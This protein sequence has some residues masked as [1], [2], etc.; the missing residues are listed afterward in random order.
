MQFINISLLFEDCE[1]ERKEAAEIK[2]YWGGEDQNLYI[3]FWKK[4]GKNEKG[5]RSSLTILAN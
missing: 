1:P 3:D 4:Y 2:K 5:V